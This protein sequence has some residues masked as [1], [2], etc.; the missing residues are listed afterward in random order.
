MKYR[1][2]RILKL[3][4]DCIE[5]EE[6][7]ADE[8]SVEVKKVKEPNGSKPGSSVTGSGEVDE[9]TVEVEEA[10]ELSS[11]PGSSVPG[12]GEPG[13]SGI[14]NDRRRKRKTNYFT[15]HDSDD[16][17]FDSDDSILDKTYEISSLE[18]NSE[19]DSEDGD[20]FSSSEETE[21][22]GEEMVQDVTPRNETCWENIQ[23]TTKDF[24]LLAERDTINHEN[25]NNLGPRMRP[26]DVFRHFI[27]DDLLELIV[28]ETNEFANTQ[29]QMGFRGKSRLR[30]W[31]ETN[32]AEIVN[33]FG[34]MIIMGLNLVPSI[35]LY[36]SKDPAYHNDFVSKNMKRDR[37]LLLLKF[38]H[39]ASNE[40]ADTNN[41][42]YKIEPLLDI[43]HK[44]FQK[45]VD[46]DRTVVID[47]SMIPFRGRVHFRQYIKNK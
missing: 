23:V 29:I 1:T 32:K 45:M 5:K 17:P 18:S 27:T 35:N 42:L 20:D 8:Q 40:L 36:W 46:L 11:K 38:I 24:D 14:Q 28:H 33:F 2:N 37:F 15:E 19:D 30:F 31:T 43:L 34:V 13:C 44:N 4:L 9:Q 41:K 16:D 47:E 6:N 12:P 3:A 25:F 39:F 22:E 7:K 21:R 10:E 26:I